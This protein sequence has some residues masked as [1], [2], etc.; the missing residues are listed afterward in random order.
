MGLLV[1]FFVNNRLTH[2]CFLQSRDQQLVFEMAVQAKTV[3][4][5]S[6][7]IRLM[8][9]SALEQMLDSEM[10]VHLGRKTLAGVTDGPHTETP[11][12]L[13]SEINAG[14]NAEVAAW[15]TRRWIPFGRLRIKTWRAKWTNIITL[16]NF[17]SP[18]RT[19][20]YITNAF[21]SVNS[22]NRKSTRC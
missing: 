22:V 6:G 21:E 5:L 1:P 20:I 8:M 14:L 19:A 18:I 13:I 10:D 7:L 2:G 4:D 17:P 12:T 11:T 16:F 3:E 9:K 15:R